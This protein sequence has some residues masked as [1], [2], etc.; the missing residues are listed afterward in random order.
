VFDL[1]AAATVCT[2]CRI[3]RGEITLADIILGRIDPLDQD[4]A[5][6]DSYKR[7]NEDHDL[8]VEGR[9]PKHICVE[10]IQ[11]HEMGKKLDE[12]RPYERV[13]C[14]L[15]HGSGA[16]TADRICSFCKGSIDE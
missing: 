8:R 12:P 3:G 14:K 11:T 15:K 9:L 6:A 4:I 1:G 5:Y 7:Q 13:E 10:V 2:E 16:A